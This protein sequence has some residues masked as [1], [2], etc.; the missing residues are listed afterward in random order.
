[1]NGQKTR[2]KKGTLPFKPKAQSSRKYSTLSKDLCKDE[3]S[4]TQI[5]NTGRNQSYNVMFGLEG[6]NSSRNAYLSSRVKITTADLDLES[7]MSPLLHKECDEQLRGGKVAGINTS[8]IYEGSLIL[9]QVDEMEQ[10]TTVEADELLKRKQSMDYCVLKKLK[11]A[12]WNEYQMDYMQFQTD[13]NENGQ[14]QGTDSNKN[15]EGMYRSQTITDLFDDKQ[16]GKDMRTRMYYQIKFATL[17]VLQLLYIVSI[18]WAN[19]I[20]NVMEFRYRD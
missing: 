16:F 18:S 4:I 9:S 12:N 5:N 14:G 1:M 17:S 20:V 8:E 3:Q 6:Q 10:S 15:R 7:N 13:G 11:S 19:Y 2:K